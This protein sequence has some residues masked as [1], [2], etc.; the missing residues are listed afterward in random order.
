MSRFR[1]IHNQYMK[2]ILRLR[3]FQ[4]E[5]VWF[6]LNRTSAVLALPTGTGKTITA[7]STYSYLKDTFPDLKLLYITEKPLILQTVTQDLPTYFQNLKYT[8]IYNNSKQERQR[9]IK[10]W[11]LNRDILILNYHTVRIDFDT[12]GRA[13]NHIDNNCIAIF[14]EATNFKNP[15]AQIS[16]CIK[17]LTKATKRSYAMTATPSTSGLFDVFNICSTIGCPPYKTK[18]EFDRFHC[19]YNAVKMFYFRSGNHKAMGIGKKIP[20]TENVELYFSFRNKFKLSGSVKIISKPNMGYFSILNESNASFRWVVNQKLVTRSGL[21]LTHNNKKMSVQVSVFDNREHIGYKNVKLFKSQTDNIMFVRSKKEVAKELPPVTIS[22]VYCEED[23]ESKQA[24]I[25]LYKSEKYAASQIEISI[26]APQVYCE[27]VQQ[28]FQSDKIKQLIHFLQN[29]IP[30]E[31]C[32]VFYPFTSATRIIKYHIDRELKINSAYCSGETKDNHAEM[33]RFLNDPDC[34]VLIGT[35]TILKGLNLQAI[36]YLVTLQLP[37]TSGDYL[38]LIGRI[39]RIGNTSPKFIYNFM[40]HDTRD[41]DIYKAVME[42]TYLTYK[43]NP[44]LIDQGVIPDS[45]KGQGMT[46]SE[47]KDFLDKQLENRKQD[48]I[49]L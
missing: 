18:A 4:H 24:I 19:D 10:D 42:Q 23:K 5:A 29:D 14:D 45:Y 41:E 31:K 6:L 36:D 27:S 20:D 15:E 12:I 43:F 39:N 37:Y 44:K 33:Q 48:Y 32:I 17:L 34:R 16:K 40:A 9:T 8:Y 46:E 1:L 13:L 49:N 7:F 35:T 47:S 38:Q 2:P 3:P 25:E 22:N 26:T 11:A 30:N 21:L 28:D